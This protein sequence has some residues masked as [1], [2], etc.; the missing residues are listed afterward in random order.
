MAMLYA[1]QGNKARQGGED[2]TISLTPEQADALGIDIHDMGT[3]LDTILRGVAAIRTHHNPTNDADSEPLERDGL[4]G[5]EGLIASTT[6]L[7]GRLRAI[8][9]V[10]I[11]EHAAVGGS[12]GQLAAAMGVSRATAQGR[13]DAVTHREPTAQEEWVTR[14]PRRMR[15][16]DGTTVAGDTDWPG[17]DDR[18]LDD[19]TTITR[20]DGVTNIAFGGGSG[21]RI[22][23][24]H[25]T[26]P[27]QF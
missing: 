9:A 7:A 25:I 6:T 22:Q 26:G 23:A 3:Y 13:R 16:Y 17:S 1:A 4:W 19:D 11:R 18:A 12:Y 2:A 10:A 24:G 21:I 15:S 20:T 5:L 14:L 27:V 8:Q